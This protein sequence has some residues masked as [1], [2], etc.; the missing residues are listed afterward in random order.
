LGSASAKG[1]SL[2]PLQFA[3]ASLNAGLRADSRRSSL[4]SQAAGLD[5]ERKFDL[6]TLGART[7]HLLAAS[8]DRALPRP[9][10]CAEFL[11]RR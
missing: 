8:F 11:P 7:G 4:R 3:P 2:P 1:R 5:P 6:T 9:D 10:N